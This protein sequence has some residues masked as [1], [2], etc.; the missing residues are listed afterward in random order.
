MKNA[1]LFKPISRYLNIDFQVTEV[2][3]LATLKTLSIDIIYYIVTYITSILNNT[4]EEKVK[5]N[6]L[7]F[8]NNGAFFEV[9]QITAHFFNNIKMSTYRFWPLPKTL[10]QSHLLPQVRCS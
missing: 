9:T 2:T 6:D 8:F 3:V 7:F 10:P 5:I 4:N 1:T